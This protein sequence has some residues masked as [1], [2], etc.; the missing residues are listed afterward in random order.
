MYYEDNRDLA[1]DEKEL[2]ISLLG[3]P[4]RFMTDAGVFSKSAIDYGTR[5]LIDNF[6]PGQA[7]SL[8]DVGCGYGAMGLPLAKKHGLA[9]TM[10]DVNSRALE[11][12][13]KNALLN[14]VAVESI[15]LSDQ[16]EA[17]AGETFDSIVSNPPIRAGKEVVH[18][19]LSGAIDHLNPQGHLT[20]VIQ[21]KQGAPSAQ[22]KMLEV[23]GNC[24][25]VA[26]DKGYWILRSVKS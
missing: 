2:S 13:E 3:L 22:K 23:F 26:K 1:H 11:L 4:M 25:L 20:I 9:L 6:E 24:E 8:L 12:A 17:L 19:I 15:K 16:Y 10:V 14:Q 21:K 18:G 5:V 7:K